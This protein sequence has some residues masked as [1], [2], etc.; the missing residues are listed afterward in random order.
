MSEAVP[1]LKVLMGNL[2]MEYA[3]APHLLPI[4]GIIGKL[5]PKRKVPESKSVLR[6]MSGVCVC[7][8]VGIIS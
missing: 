8:S 7:L 1:A 5:H 4:P 6:D 2:F 3:Q